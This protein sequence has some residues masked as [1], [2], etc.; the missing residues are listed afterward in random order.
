MKADGIL[1]QQGRFDIDQPPEYLGRISPKCIGPL[2]ADCRRVDKKR[3]RRNAPQPQQRMFVKQAPHT[4]LI[5][6]TEPPT[7]VDTGQTFSVLSL[8]G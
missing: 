5:L 7:D 6:P 3:V 4:A 2:R 1:D 8:S